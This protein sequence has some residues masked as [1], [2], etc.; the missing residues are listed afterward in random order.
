M[1]TY[2]QLTLILQA[3]I[4][5]AAF[6]TLAVYYHQLRVM[7]KQLAAMQEAS[8]AQGA[9]SLVTSLQAP[10]V[11]AARQCVREVLSRK[12]L[13]EWS[14]DERRHASLVVANYDVVAGLLKANLA[15]AELIVT[16]WGPSITHCYQVLDPF[17]AEVRSRPGAD[18]RYWSNFDWLYAQVPLPK[19]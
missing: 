7:S 18:A 14:E 10:D 3:I 11:R 4:G 5:V 17:I 8:R 6:F 16:N 12:P 2:E 15:P 1:T 19:A 9:L 13:A